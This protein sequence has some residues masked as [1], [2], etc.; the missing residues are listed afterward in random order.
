MANQRNDQVSTSGVSAKSRFISIPTRMTVIFCALYFLMYFDRVNIS[1]A[2]ASIM[3]DFHLSKMGLGIV[4]SAFSWPYLVGQ[5]VGGWSANKIGVR[6]TLA[7][8]VL[9]AA[10]ATFASGLTIG[11][12]TLFVA[13]LFVGIGEG[14]C[15]SAA[16]Q[17]MKHW[18][19]GKRYGF[20]QGVTHASSRFGG[21]VAHLLW[22]GASRWPDGGPHFRMRFGN[23]SLG[24][25][26][27]V[28]LC[29]GPQGS[30]SITKAELVDLVPPT[31][32]CGTPALPGGR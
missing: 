22:L 27:V 28:E 24:C 5:W 23:F 8:C 19:S 21:A 11:V 10:V 13:R 1:M 7:I 32:R 18:Y 29:R 16:T 4:F 12:A 9:L 17:G 2:A 25:L 3:K 14:P 30:P 15:F 31:R 20:L 26:L 6:N